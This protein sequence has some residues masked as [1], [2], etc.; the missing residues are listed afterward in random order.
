MLLCVLDEEEPREEGDTAPSRKQPGCPGAR[1][2]LW[3]T[4]GS[5]DTT[6]AALG[7]HTVGKKRGFSNIQA[8]KMGVSLFQGT[9]KIH[10]H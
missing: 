3:G 4:W 2:V 7:E 10:L 6:S 8:S 9:D 1:G 5:R